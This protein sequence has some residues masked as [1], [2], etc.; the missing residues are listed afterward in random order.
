MANPTLS[1][2]DAERDVKCRNCG[3]GG[4]IGVEIGAVS[5]RCID[6]DRAYAEGAAEERERLLCELRAIVTIIDALPHPTPP[7]KQTSGESDAAAS[8][9]CTPSP[10]PV[11][12]PGAILAKVVVGPPLR[13][14]ARG[15]FDVGMTRTNSKQLSAVKIAGAHMAKVLEAI[16]AHYPPNAA[17]GGFVLDRKVLP[18]SLINDIHLALAHWGSV[19]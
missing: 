4:P 1:E 5:G 19:E 12:E 8:T 15:S 10:A 11:E 14:D 18:P 3:F 13:F 16:A 2:R 7:A 9:G 17:Q 6:C